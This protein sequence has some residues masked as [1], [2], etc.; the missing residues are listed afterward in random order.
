MAWSAPGTWPPP[1][2]RSPRWSGL[3]VRAAP[4]TLVRNPSADTQHREGV[5]RGENPDDSPCPAIQGLDKEPPAPPHCGSCLP[6]SAP[7]VPPF[8]PVPVARVATQRAHLPRGI[9]GK[10]CLSVRPHRDQ[11]PALAMDRA[12]ADE[13]LGEDLVPRRGRSPPTEARRSHLGGRCTDR[14][15]STAVGSRRTGIR[16]ERRTAATVSASAKTPTTGCEGEAGIVSIGRGSEPDSPT[17][18]PRQTTA[19]TASSPV[20]NGERRGELA[21]GRREELLD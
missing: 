17:R 18:L 20:S 8:D 19:E 5:R 12:Y 14:L 21:T 15:H 16:H 13:W 4:S 1:A 3:T 10:S 2:G 6:I 11:R 7:R 9:E